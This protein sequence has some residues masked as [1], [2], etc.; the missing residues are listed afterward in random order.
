MPI[1]GSSS[2]SHVPTEG[3]P[4]A[5]TSARVS[6]DEESNPHPPIGDSRSRSRSQMPDGNAHS[7]SIPP[8]TPP[9]DGGAESPRDRGRHSARFSL[10]N[11]I[12][13]AVKERVRSNSPIVERGRSSQKSRDVGTVSGGKGKERET[14]LEGLFPHLHLP[15]AIKHSHSPL[16]AADE[17]DEDRKEFGNGWREFK[18]GKFTSVYSVCSQY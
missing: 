10:A 6:F 3:Q 11:T 15:S 18:K 4:S 13:D 9:H 16:A 17:E 14:P 12:L 7:H 8:P 5:S 2:L 1:S